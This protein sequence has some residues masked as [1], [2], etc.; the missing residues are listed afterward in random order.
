[1]KESLLERVLFIDIPGAFKLDMPELLY[2]LLTI[3]SSRPGM[4]VDYKNIGNDLKIDQRTISLYLSYLE[5]ALFLQKLYNY[6][7]NLLTSEKKIKRFFLSNTAFTLS[8]NPNVDFS[9]VMKQYFA[10]MLKTRFFL[11]PP[12]KKKRKLT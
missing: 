12:P 2:K 5:Y 7:P 11:R 4:Y 8:L 6:S 10:N 9:G 3:L 1:M